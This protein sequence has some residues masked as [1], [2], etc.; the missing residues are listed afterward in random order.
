M[1]ERTSL[2]MMFGSMIV[3]ILLGIVTCNSAPLASNNTAP[4]VQADADVSAQL[5]RMQARIDELGVQVGD[6]AG[7]SIY[8]FGTGG[9]GMVVALLVYVLSDRVPTLRRIKNAMKGKKLIP[10]SDW[11]ETK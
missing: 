2:S 7:G 9:L 10:L 8:N 6:K 1:R 11:T 4:L 5:V 3:M